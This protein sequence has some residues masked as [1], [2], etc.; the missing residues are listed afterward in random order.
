[1][2]RLLPNI[3]YVSLVHGG[4][5]FLET[6]WYTAIILYGTTQVIFI[7]I[8]MEVSNI[9]A[10]FFQEIQYVNWIPAK[11]LRNLHLKCDAVL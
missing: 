10:C 4:S 2:N 11:N 6:H 9:M 8:S 3:P 5:V 7:Y 1:M